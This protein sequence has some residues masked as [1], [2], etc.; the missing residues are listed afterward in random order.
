MVAIG[1]GL[2]LVTPFQCQL[3]AQPGA[4]VPGTGKQVTHPR[5]KQLVEPRFLDG[6][7]VPPEQRSDLRMKLAEWIVSHPYQLF[8][9]EIGRRSSHLATPG[10]TSL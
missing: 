5:T 8:N 2:L 3:Q 7:V 1:A 6:T 10:R 9:A 4:L